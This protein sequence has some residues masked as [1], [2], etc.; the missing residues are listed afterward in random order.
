MQPALT[1]HQLQ[2][3]AACSFS[4]V[5]LKHGDLCEVRPEQQCRHQSD[6]TASRYDQ[7][8]AVHEAKD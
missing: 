1:E 2:R 6:W 3:P 5:A 8:T 4:G 7:P